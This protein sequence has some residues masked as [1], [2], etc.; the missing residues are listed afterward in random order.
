MLALN[1]VAHKFFKFKGRRGLNNLRLNPTIDCSFT[2][3]MEELAHVIAR[4]EPDTPNL[5]SKWFRANQARLLSRASG[6][7]GQVASDLFRFMKEKPDNFTEEEWMQVRLIITDFILCLEPPADVIPPIVLRDFSNPL[8]FGNLLLAMRK[9]ITQ[10]VIDDVISVVS[11]AQSFMKSAGEMECS[12][13]ARTSAWYLRVLTPFLKR[14]VSKQILIPLISEFVDA[15]VAATVDEIKYD[16]IVL[17]GAWMSAATELG[18]LPDTLRRDFCRVFEKGPMSPSMFLVHFFPP[19][20]QSFTRIPE[21]ESMSCISELETIL[22]FFDWSIFMA[23]NELYVRFDWSAAFRLWPYA[24]TTKTQEKILGFLC[25]GIRTYSRKPLFC[26][27]Y[28]IITKDFDKIFGRLDREFW[29]MD[30]IVTSLDSSTR[31][32]LQKLQHFRGC[33]KLSSQHKFSV[34]TKNVSFREQSN[35]TFELDRELFTTVTLVNYRSLDAAIESFVEYCEKGRELGNRICSVANCLFR[36]VGKQLVAIMTEERDNKASALRYICRVTSSWTKL[37]IVVGHMKVMLDTYR[38]KEILESPTLPKRLERDPGKW[39]NVVSPE[40]FQWYFHFLGLCPDSCYSTVAMVIAQEL[41]KGLKR[42]KLSFYLVACFRMFPDS[43][44]FTSIR[45]SF[46]GSVLNRMFEITAMNTALFTSASANQSHLLY[47]WIVFSIRLGSARTGD[48]ENP[49]LGLV[50]RNYQKLILASAFAP[51]DVANQADALR[52][53]FTYLKYVKLHSPYPVTRDEKKTRSQAKSLLFANFQETSQCEAIKAVLSLCHYQPQSHFISFQQLALFLDAAFACENGAVIE[54]A[55]DICLEKL[56]P[57]KLVKFGSETD[58]LRRLFNSYLMAMPRVPREKALSVL[59]GTPS[60]APWFLAAEKPKWSRGNELAIDG[61]G[62]RMS[63]V[64]A[65]VSSQSEM[66]TDVVSAVF[67]L[68]TQCFEIVRKNIDSTVY[69]E[70]VFRSLIFILAHCWSFDFMKERVSGYVKVLVEHFGDL[71]VR[72]D[73]DVF[74]LSLF[75]VAGSARSQISRAVL[76]WADMFLSYVKKHP[77]DEDIMKTAIDRLSSFVQPETRLFSMLLGFSL[78][79]KVFPEYIT[80]AHIRSFLIQT[81]SISPMDFEFVETLNRLLQ[82]FL[83][84]QTHAGRELFVQMVYEIVCPLSILVRMMLMKRVRKLGIPLRIRSLDDIEKGQSIV[85]WYQR[86]TLV[87]LCGLQ[88]PI[89]LSDSL[90]Q[91]ILEML[92]LRGQGQGQRLEHTSRILSL[93]RAIIR[94]RPLF[95]ALTEKEENESLFRDALLNALATRV[96]PLRRLAKKCFRILRDNYSD[97]PRLFGHIDEI[98][99]NP[100]KI[101]QFYLGQPERIVF[102]RYFTKIVPDNVPPEVICRFFEAVFDYAGKTEAEQ[103]KYTNCFVWILKFLTVKAYVSRPEVRNLV[104]STSARNPSYFQEFISVI[105]RMWRHHEIPLM[106]LTQKPV[107]KFLILFPDETVDFLF[108]PDCHDCNIAFTRDLIMNDSSLKFFEAFLN[109]GERKVASNE[110]TK[111]NSAAFALMKRLAKD[112]VFGSNPR[113]LSFLDGCLARLAKHMSR[114]DVHGNN[115][116]SM[117]IMCVVAIVRTYRFSCDVA[118]AT[119]VAKF[120]LHP[121]FQKSHVSRLLITTL[122][123]KTTPEFVNQVLNYLIESFEHLKPCVVGRMFPHALKHCTEIDSDMLFREHIPKWMKKTSHQAAVIAVII[124]LLRKRAPSQEILCDICMHLKD[125]LASPNIDVCVY[126]LKLCVQLMKMQLL[127]DVVFQSLLRTVLTHNKFCEMP[128]SRYLVRLFRIVPSNWFDEISQETI[129]SLILFVQANFLTGRGMWKSLKNEDSLVLIAPKLFEHLPFSLLSSLSLHVVGHIRH[130]KEKRETPVFASEKKLI[131]NMLTGLIRVCLA[132]NPKE[133]EI[134]V[135]AKVFYEYMRVLIE[136][137]TFES[138]V[139]PLFFDVAVK[140]DITPFPVTLLKEMKSVADPMSFSIVCLA[141]KINPGLLAKDYDNFVKMTLDYAEVVENAVNATY[142]SVFLKAL[143]SDTARFSQVAPL[144]ENV[145]NKLLQAETIDPVPRIVV[146]ANLLMEKEWVKCCKGL[147]DYYARC[148]AANQ[149]SRAMIEFLTLAVEF[150]PSDRQLS[151]IEMIHEQL[152]VDCYLSSVFVE[153][154]PLILESHRVMLSVKGYL[155]DHLAEILLLEESCPVDAYVLAITKLEPCPIDVRSAFVQIFVVQAYRCNNSDRLSFLE[156]AI[157][158][159]PEDRRVRIVY[160]FQRVPVVLWQDQF[161]PILVALV[162]KRVPMWQPLFLLSHRLISIGSDLASWTFEELMD[163]NNRCEFERFLVAILRNPRKSFRH[164]QI[165]SGLIRIFHRTKTRIH[166]ALAQKA[167]HYTGHISLLE[168]FLPCD[169]A[170]RN[171]LLMVHQASDLVYGIYRQTLTPRQASAVAMTFLNEYEAAQDCYLSED[172]SEFF[173]RM[174]RVNSHFIPSNDSS[175]RFQPLSSHVNR[176]DSLVIMLEEAVSAFTIKNRELL[177]EKICDLRLQNM[178][179]TEKRQRLSHFEKERLVLIEAM[180][181]E[182]LGKSTLT[183]ESTFHMNDA[184]AKMFAD[185]KAFLSGTKQTPLPEID[186]TEPCI[187]LASSMRPQFEKVCGCTTRGL[188]AIGK[189]HIEEYFGKISRRVA[190]NSMTATDWQQLAAFSFNLY[191]AQPSNDLFMASFVAYCKVLNA[192]SDFP[193]YIVNEAAARIITMCRIGFAENEQFTQRVI[194]GQTIFERRMGDI[195]RFW[196]QQLV[197]L[198]RAPWFCDKACELFRDMSYRSLIYAQKDQ[199]KPLE[200]AMNK[201]L[202]DKP[203]KQIAM[204]EVCQAYLSSLFAIRFDEKQNQEEL[205]AFAKEA[206]RLP[207]TD[208]IDLLSVR[209]LPAK[210]PFERAVKPL[211]LS[212]I[213]LVGDFREFVEKV[214]H[215]DNDQLILFI[216]ELTHSSVSLKTIKEN[217]SRATQQINDNLPFIFPLRVERPYQITLLQ[218]LDGFEFLSSD[219]VMIRMVTS[220]D[221]WKYYIAQKSLSDKG[222]HKSV[223]TLA[224]TLVLFRMLL[225]RSYSASSR[226][227]LAFPSQFFEIEASMIFV[228]VMDHPVTFEALFKHV[229]MMTCNEWL[230]ENVVSDIENPPRFAPY[231]RKAPMMNM[232]IPYADQST[233]HLTESG[234]ERIKEIP[235]DA[236]KRLMLEIFPEEDYLKMRANLARSASVACFI[237]HL[238]NAR[239]PSMQ[240]CL[241][242]AVSGIIPILHSDFDHGMI[243]STEESPFTAFRVSPNIVSS[244]GMSLKGDSLLTMAAVAKTLT[245]HIESVRSWIETMI[246]DEDFDVGKKRSIPDLMET[247]KIIENKFLTF[248]PPSVPNADPAVCE[249]WLVGIEEFINKSADPSVQPIEAIPWF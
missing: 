131:E 191:C 173:K 5:I 77:F 109:F 226:N 55:V 94:K 135:W 103:L 125:L 101:V 150:M 79:I 163:E 194:E 206:A 95:D 228:P 215:M 19:W 154:M 59:S 72:G 177:Q 157:A 71:F 171:R 151:Y 102:Y 41:F 197:E 152:P 3:Q 22:R 178:S 113:F 144:I 91:E 82:E 203:T 166:V 56:T 247:R 147:W 29:F 185:F 161:L 105:L 234:K 108:G 164:R 132:A 168:F 249:E 237:R 221:S 181:S 30:Y 110:V 214:K 53:V 115:D 31:A 18:D 160:M 153:K 156:K 60:L 217:V 43:K 26:N 20:L 130:L 48:Q 89:V 145:L 225:Q 2:P 216:Q 83:K 175:A 97:R 112:K 24:K 50:M 114:G 140:M 184:F 220:M 119:K 1:C 47:S 172:G 244:L 236:I 241:G 208:G 179:T 28:R 96:V 199:T 44:G 69:S 196:L 222:Y 13:Y 75:D 198:A 159:L 204:M 25:F 227:L 64:L 141:G 207:S 84:F 122:F 162:A 127:P 8:F 78:I 52:T 68:V 158:R 242:C 149:H 121:F 243:T 87:F 219:M 12:F 174:G 14:H 137:Q 211:S 213:S 98:A 232:R 58:L 63:T 146:C 80:L 36:I 248:C 106:A 201:L 54:T 76:L 235:T 16:F 17:A 9:P 62:Y 116:Y 186:G 233:L 165:V 192:N 224:N 142:L 170:P 74:L 27:S 218:I 240:R 37:L 11:A 205:L 73:S 38:Q 200:D 245:K 32:I 136:L 4:K 190:D 193:Q 133:D 45:Q 229:M 104:F 139:L 231:D 39:L 223:L 189:D 210:T 99:K 40:V 180:C 66:N 167:I 49:I 176:S 148:K 81:T 188:I 93:I 209:K 143:A 57:K 212:Q 35:S 51:R 15:F 92:S 107:T 61:L 155:L 183:N 70:T 88:E 85:L 7:L 6:R 195:W 67:V 124:Q 100:E 90:K 33:G 129:E 120:T 187:L 182:M 138:Q 86:L 126:C 111:L 230:K 21:G 134:H 202:M 10:S 65:A 117:I 128:Y 238:F 123:T 46:F 169:V 42:G 23:Y 118:Q 246:Q 34:D 239:Y